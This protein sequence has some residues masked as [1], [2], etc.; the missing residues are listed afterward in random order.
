ME[1]KVEP[2]FGFMLYLATMVIA[3]VVARKRGQ[4]VLLYGIFI[5][6]GG[7]LLARIIYGAGGGSFAAGLGA[8]AVP[9]IALLI[10][11]SSKTSEQ[12]AVDKG[13]HGEFKKCLFCAESVRTEAI[14]CKH[15]GSSI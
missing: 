8:F 15:C 9:L 10:S 2:I 7:P 6:L 3:C 5:L 14:K 11:L 12:I 13:A 4:S 1:A